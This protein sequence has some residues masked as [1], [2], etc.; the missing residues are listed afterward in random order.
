MLCTALGVAL[1]GCSM[2][3]IPEAAVATAQP[4]DHLVGQNLDALIARFGP[5]ARTSPADNDQTTVVWQFET[6]ARTSPPTGAGGL[7][8]DGGSPGYVAQDYSP[9]CRVTAVV[10]T[11]T[12]V[13]TQARTE[14][15]NGTGSSLLRRSE[16]ICSQ[17]I[18]TKPRT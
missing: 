15:S 9:F 2:P 8:G 18:P 6:P 11:T 5:P 17:Y 14:E 10:S 13:V 4:A 16:S 12:G 1:G 7:Y 3:R